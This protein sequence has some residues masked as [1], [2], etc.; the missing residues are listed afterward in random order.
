MN[1]QYV[2]IVDA[3]STG[4]AL[5]PQFK[6]H[7]YKILH[8][9]SSR[10]TV[11]DLL[12]TFKP[13]DFNKLFIFEENLDQLVHQLEEINIAHIIAGTE[14]GVFLADVLSEKI[15]VPGN[16]PGTSILR[17]NK[18]KMHEALKLSNIAHAKQ[19]YFH[20]IGEA[21]TW[22]DEQDIWPLVAKPLDSA[23]SDSV[24]F[25]SNIEEL[26]NAC[27]LILNHKNKLGFKNDG[28]LIQECLEGQQY[29]VNAVTLDGKHAITEIWKDKRNQGICDIEELLPYEGKVQKEIIEYVRTVLTCLGIEQGPSHTELMF[30]NRGPV[31]IESGARMMGTILEE[32]VVSAIGDSHVTTTVERYASPQ[33]FMRRLENGYTLNKNL[34]CITLVSNETG[35][36]A[37]NHVLEKLKS[38]KSFYR[39]F[40]TPQIGE[41]IYKTVDLFTNPG[42]IYLLH[43]SNEQILRDYE[44]I[45]KLEKEGEFFL[46][47]CSV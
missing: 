8:V 29:F 17:R 27:N 32:A 15:G 40:H 28:V 22:A 38:L 9:Q 7:G 12:E 18:Y 31:L 46:V 6:R 34:F 5:A 16:N 47:E 30:T 39:V 26:T 10:D 19:G 35:I 23:G 37:E 2:C 21:I 11:K 25:C 36:V 20:T 4:A 42:I 45:R 41:K 3:F 43:D 24:S 44:E 14:T 13:E 33:K 1:E